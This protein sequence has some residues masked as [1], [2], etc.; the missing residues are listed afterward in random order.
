MLT[1]CWEL[2]EVKSFPGRENILSHCPLKIWRWSLTSLSSRK[3]QMPW[4][5][6]DAHL[7]PITKSVLQ[8]PNAKH[9]QNLAATEKL[10]SMHS[11]SLWIFFLGLIRASRNSRKLQF[12]QR[13][14]IVSTTWPFTRRTRDEEQRER[15][16]RKRFTGR[17][18]CRTRALPKICQQNFL[19]RD[20]KYCIHLIFGMGACKILLGG[21][22][23]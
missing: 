12:R 19:S 17:Q 20:K 14:Q 13:N 21:L 23:C 9:F 7:D 10:E 16:R 15:E 4:W 11:A 22:F 2:S 1:R 6:K 5:E 3:V 18:Y 8:L